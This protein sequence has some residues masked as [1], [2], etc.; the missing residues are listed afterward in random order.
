MLLF[1]SEPSRLAAQ[2][3]LVRV[4]M[5]WAVPTFTASGSDDPDSGLTALDCTVKMAWNVAPLMM[6]GLPPVLV[7]MVRLVG[8]QD[9]LQRA[10]AGDHERRG[11][12]D[13]RTPDRRGQLVAQHTG[14]HGADRH[15]GAVPT[16]GTGASSWGTIVGGGIVIL[17]MSPVLMMKSAG[18]R[19][20]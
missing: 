15:S 12:V 6:I 20:S 1:T 14:G 16:I 18:T 7:G 11:G 19:P 2:P 9:D 3:A 13:Q 17:I 4:V 8:H 10:R 5:N